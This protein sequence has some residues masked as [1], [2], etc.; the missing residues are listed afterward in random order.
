[1]LCYGASGPSEAVI[2]VEG[3]PVRRLW[4]RYNL[5]L[6]LLAL[7]L[8]SWAAQLWTQWREY[9]ADEAAHGAAATYDGYAWVFLSRTFENWQSEFLQLLSFVVLT[10]FLIF[11]GSHESKDAQEAQHEEVMAALFDIRGR[12][13]PNGTS[14][15][16]IAELF[17]DPEGT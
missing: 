4:S 2:G 11:Q 12:L 9:V 5:G 7:F 1:M 15:I 8:A 3:S 17:R 14:D 13:D 6:V 16:V 10:S